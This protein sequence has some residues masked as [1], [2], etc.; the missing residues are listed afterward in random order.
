MIICVN[1]MQ[2]AENS[3]LSKKKVSKK[4]KLFF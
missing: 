1:A 2:R 3:E 4:Q